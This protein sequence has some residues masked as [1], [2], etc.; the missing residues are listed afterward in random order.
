MVEGLRV[1]L[2]SAQW[3]LFE[4]SQ[5]NAAGARRCFRSGLVANPNDAFVWQSL[6][7]LEVREGDTDAARA[8][9]SLA[10]ERCKKVEPRRRPILHSVHPLGIPLAICFVFV[11]KVFPTPLVIE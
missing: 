2:Y 7:A 6:A 8:A 4:R 3:G 5:R 10:T 9:F 11:P 1:V